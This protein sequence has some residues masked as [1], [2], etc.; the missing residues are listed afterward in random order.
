VHEG[1][2]SEAAA[3]TKKLEWR[4]MATLSYEVVKMPL[5]WYFSIAAFLWGESA[6][7][8]CYNMLFSHD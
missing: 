1:N 5:M 7:V 6:A 2:T 3:A 4:Q 8:T